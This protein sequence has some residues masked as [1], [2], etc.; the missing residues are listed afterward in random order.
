MSK[1]GEFLRDVFTPVLVLMLGGVVAYDHFVPH[2]PAV[3]PAAAVDGKALGRQFAG[4]VATAFG[5]A[6]VAAA[7]TLEQGKS[8]SDAQATLQTK[9]QDGRTKAFTTLVAPE[10]SKILG[11]GA[12]PTDAA[13]R[14][15]VV[16]L[17]RDFAAGLKGGR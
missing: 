2:E 10:F 11:E 12:E 17:W 6:W 16:K 9:W 3:V 4:S 1:I 13:Q 15:A 14:A 7:D 8:I 5:D